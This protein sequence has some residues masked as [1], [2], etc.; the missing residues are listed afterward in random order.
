MRQTAALLSALVLAA[1][2]VPVSGGQDSPESPR[3]VHVVAERFTFT[4]ERITVEQGTTV[5]IRLTSEDTAHG[6][7]LIG[8]GDIDVE[9][10][11]RGRGDVRVRFEANEPGEFTFECSRVCGAGHGFMRGTMRVLLRDSN[12]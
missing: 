12:D 9:I 7:R 2:T 8:P 5:E 1:F 4:P 3:V 6:F 10:P 11:K